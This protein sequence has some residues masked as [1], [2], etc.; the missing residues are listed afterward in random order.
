MAVNGWLNK[1][2]N[3]GQVTPT[4]RHSLK[5]SK[6]KQKINTIFLMYSSLK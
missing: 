3:K 1:V 4:I 2:V 6:K 5:T